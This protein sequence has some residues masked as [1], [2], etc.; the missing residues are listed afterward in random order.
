MKPINWEEV[1]D[2][3]YAF[4]DIKSGGYVLKV[5]S[6][7]EEQGYT[8][9]WGDTYDR[10]VV[11]YEIAEGD[12]AGFF[13]ANNRPSWSHEHEFRIADDIESVPERDRWRYEQFLDRFL[14]AIKSSN[15]MKGT[16]SDASQL[17]G[18]LFGAV[19]RH[20]LYTKADGSDGSALQIQ[21]IYS[22]DRIRSGSY[23]PAKDI[24]SRKEQKPQATTSS[25]TAYS[26][27]DLPF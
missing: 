7:T 24:D 12:D 3:A 9:Q 5:V 25:A 16:I 17:N 23:T 10:I 21:S 15:D 20:R 1:D 8:N 26:D 19:L 2:P 22:A 18:L 13:E 14:P 27:E 6:A 11:C 4:A